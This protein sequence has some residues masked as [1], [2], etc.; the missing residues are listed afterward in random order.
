MSH[1]TVTTNLLSHS[2]NIL[3][4]LLRSEPKMIEIYIVDQ[5]KNNAVMQSF[6]EICRKINVIRENSKIEDGKEKYI[7]MRQNYKLLVIEYFRQRYLTQDYVASDSTKFVW[8]SFQFPI[9][10]IGM[11]VNDEVF[12]ENGMGWNQWNPMENEMVNYKWIQFE[13]LHGNT[14]DSMRLI[15]CWMS[16]GMRIDNQHCEFERYDPF[17]V[18][19][20]WKINTIKSKGDEIPFSE[21]YSDE[22]NKLFMP[23]YEM[24]VDG[25]LHDRPQLLLGEWMK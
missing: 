16:Q 2:S 21:W 6:T 10:M 5:F 25:I 19:K 8:S 20:F 17:N 9:L 18:L 13:Y 14:L 1:D 23:C 15:R 11:L 22:I 24:V 7:K 3:H 12:I 4:V